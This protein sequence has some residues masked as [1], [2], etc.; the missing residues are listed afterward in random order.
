MVRLTP[1]KLVSLR[2]DS[3]K[4]FNEAAEALFRV[5]V[6]TVVFGKA[7]VKYLLRSAKKRLKRMGF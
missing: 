4:L 3:N 2:R 7:R 1:E 6:P 5:E